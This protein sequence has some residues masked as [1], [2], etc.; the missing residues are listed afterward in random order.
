MRMKGSHS[1]KRDRYSHIISERDVPVSILMD[2]Y[3]QN[4]DLPMEEQIKN[5]EAMAD[6]I[7]KEYPYRNGKQYQK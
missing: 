3:Y 7:E 1:M 4:K 5:R 6:K 2:M